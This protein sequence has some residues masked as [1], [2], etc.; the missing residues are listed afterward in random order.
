MR[1]HTVRNV[2]NVRRIN[3]LPDAFYVSM[4][5]YLGLE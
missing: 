4:L 5:G 2:L 1:G 3:G